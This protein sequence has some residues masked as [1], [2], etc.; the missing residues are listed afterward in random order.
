MAFVWVNPAN[1]AQKYWSGIPN[2]SG[3]PAGWVLTGGSDGA[4]D[5]AL[6]TYVG[7]VNS[8]GFPAYAGDGNSGNKNPNGLL[9]G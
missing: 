5:S 4:S 8:G 7:G 2:D 6:Q 3:A 1:Y 9:N